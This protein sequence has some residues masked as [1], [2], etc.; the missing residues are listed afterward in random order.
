[1]RRSLFIFLVIM[2]VGAILTST[3]FIYK[4]KKEDKEQKEIFEELEIIASNEDAPK[5]EKQE[6]TI[7]I[8]EL[9][10]I[11]NDIVGWIKIENSNI[12]YPIM[13]TKDRP[14]YYL[15]RNF[16]K[17]YSALGTP[18]LAENCNIEES[19][20]LI[21]YGHHVKRKESFWRTREL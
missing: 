9:Y 20:N 21:I 4:D 3:F 5:E 19:Y 6:E 14:N 11:N 10:K 12:S 16:Y 15:N 13:Q 7:N 18:Y 17:K 1:M 8:E 2:L